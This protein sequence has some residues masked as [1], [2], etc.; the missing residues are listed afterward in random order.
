MHEWSLE[1]YMSYGSYL[2]G[3]YVPVKS[4]TPAH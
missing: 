3:T 1:S 4:Y 2:R